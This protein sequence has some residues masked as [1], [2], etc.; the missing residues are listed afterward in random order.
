[1]EQ[2]IDQWIRIDEILRRLNCKGGFTMKANFTLTFEIAP[3]VQPIVLGKTDF[4]GT[5]GSPEN[6]SISPSGGDGG[7]FTT[8]VPDPTQIPPGVVIGSDGSITGTPT[9]DGNF[10]VNIEV[11]DKNG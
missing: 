1:M 6:D 9:K 10:S 4:Q 8:N 3:Q 2:L 11:A 7:P 5:V